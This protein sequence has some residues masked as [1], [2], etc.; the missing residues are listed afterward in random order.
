MVI[1]KEIW[2]SPYQCY[3]TLHIY[4]PDQCS[5][6]NPA[7]VLYMFD[8]H[9]LFYDEDATYGK[10]WGLKEYCDQNQVNLIIVGLECNHE[11]NERLSEFTP[12]DFYDRPWGQIDQKGQVLAEWMAYELK[13]WIDE[14]FHT[15]KD[16]MHTYIGGSSMGGIMSLYV[17]LNYS[18]IFSKAACLSPHIYPMFNKVIKG[19]P[20]HVHPDSSIYMSWGAREYSRHDHFVKVTSQNLRIVSELMKQDGLHIFP[21]VYEKGTHSEASWE[22]ELPVFFKELKLYK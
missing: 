10:S 15:K 9:N 17:L 14:Q 11:G 20:K 19:L 16:R 22:K 8:G 21:H 12:Y 13:P 4:V 3:R 18:D 7:G 5:F 2:I 6:K 1:K